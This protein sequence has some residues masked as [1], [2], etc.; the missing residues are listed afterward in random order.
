M[1]DPRLSVIVP[2]FNVSEYIDQCLESILAQS[3]KDYEVLL[4]DDGSTDGSTEII[5]K[6]VARDGRFKVLHQENKGPGAAR[7][8]GISQSNGDFIVFMDP[9]DWLPSSDTY[10]TLIEKI[11]DSECVVAGGSLCFYDQSK[12]SYVPG[13]VPKAIFLKEEVLEFKDY[14]Y[15]YFFQRF[16]YSTSFLKDNGICFPDLRR[17]QDTL[18]LLNVMGACGRFLAIPEMTYVYRGCNRPAFF[19]SRD[20]SLA[21]MEGVRRGLVKSAEEHWSTIHLDTLRIVTYDNFLEATEPMREELDDDYITL[22]ERIVSAVDTHLLQTRDYSLSASYPRY[23]VFLKSFLWTAI[24]L[25]NERKREFF[26]RLI[27]KFGALEIIRTLIFNYLDD[28]DSL[29]G[30]MKWIPNC[31]ERRKIQKVGIFNEA[32]STGGVERCISYFI[33]MFQKMGYEVVLFTESYP[34]ED[35]FEIHPDM[36]IVL[37]GRKPRDREHWIE[38]AGILAEAIESAGIDVLHYNS[39]WKSDLVFDELVCKLVSK[40][41]FILHHHN[42]FSAMLA[43]GNPIFGNAIDLYSMSDAIVTMS[44]IDQLYF[45]LRGLPAVYI[46]NPIGNIVRASSGSDEY[47]IVW[48]G[49]FVPNHK[50]PIEM[51]AILEQVKRSIPSVKLYMVGDGADD[52]RMS[53]EDYVD[54]HG[55][56]QNIE[57]TGF[58]SDVDRY[59]KKAS[60][61]VMT[62]CI[63]GFP[64]VVSE[65]KSHCLPL[66][67]YDLPYVEMIRDGAGVIRVPQGDRSAVASAVVQ[68]LSDK[69]LCHRTGEAGFESLSSY[70]MS[71]VEGMWSQLFAY[72]S[73]IEGIDLQTPDCNSEDVNILVN[74]LTY[75]AKLSRKDY[76]IKVA[77]RPIECS[78]SYDS[79]EGFIAIPTG[80][81]SRQKIGIVDCYG[82]NI[83]MTKKGSSL[84]SCGWKDYYSL[85]VFDADLA[86]SLG[87]GRRV[88]FQLSSNLENA[89]A[90]PLS[91]FAD[92][93]LDSLINV[94]VNGINRL[95]SYHTEEDANGVITV[96]D[97]DLLIVDKNDFSH[98]CDFDAICKKVNERE[99]K[100]IN[101][102]NLALQGVKRCLL[103]TLNRHDDKSVIS[104]AKKLR[105][106]YPTIQFEILSVVN[107]PELEDE[108]FYRDI[109]SSSNVVVRSIAMNDAPKDGWKGNNTLWS[110]L[111]FR[112][113]ESVPEID[114]HFV[115]DKD[116]DQAMRLIKTDVSG[117][118][119]ALLKILIKD[120]NP[121]YADKIEQLV[122]EVP[123]SES[124]TNE[125]VGFCDR[126]LKLDYVKSR[127][128]SEMIHTIASKITKMNSV[129][130][131]DALMRIGLAFRDGK[132]VMK[133]RALA[134][135]FFKA[136]AL[137]GSSTALGTA[138]AVGKL[139]AIY[140]PRMAD[141]DV[142]A[143]RL[144]ARAYQS[145]GRMDDAKVCYRW[146]MEI[147]P[148]WVVFEYT[149][150]LFDSGRPEDLSECRDICERFASLDNKDALYRLGRMYLDGRGVERDSD[151]ARELLQDAMD[152]GS[153]IAGELLMNGDFSERCVRRVF[154][155]HKKRVQKTERSA[156]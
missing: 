29:A 28:K 51:L 149:K 109:F 87:I 10:A 53:L 49:R 22:F 104:F 67:V 4:V 25:P 14:Q 72:L 45:R 48:S 112:F 41:H 120:Y 94:L 89:M 98:G 92:Y 123:S 155:L 88:D 27:S 79:S 6:Y 117:S 42:V 1:D 69:S 96:V 90:A 106:M 77:T 122:T 91:E 126:I 107:Y 111:F 135:R 60:V 129:E 154:R 114:T 38:R 134:N 121:S 146:V 62:S 70:S 131:S 99:F 16:I 153:T 75:H 133:D 15:D 13:H 93:P 47:A 64:M 8:L 30:L 82:R 68:L 108:I 144:L 103:V 5:E 37:P 139:E 145:V 147:R 43:R 115:S 56:K 142:V 20:K 54:V 95:F 61:M 156:R 132:D 59:Y 148:D 138:D 71:I 9:D 102:F 81:L 128:E 85:P 35:A 52:V 65:C 125:L 34:E 11:T 116:L 150:A 100:I 136:A 18:F 23:G 58:V 46:P 63:E 19:F 84:L 31:H 119:E 140:G 118:K 130:D 152:A 44:R 80:C 32:I 12:K 141:G 76:S 33:P 17:F 74:T 2:V 83:P 66:V 36:R 86:A 55:L 110:R 57:F 97:S 21:W 124:I 50:Q 7:N 113:N 151:R 78:Y 40:V 127:S 24:Y 101:A 3:M 73:G 143:G 39:Y 105:G 137:L 26:E